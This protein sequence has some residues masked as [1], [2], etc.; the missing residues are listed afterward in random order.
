M[1]KYLM[2]GFAAIVFCGAI[3]S[4]SHDMDSGS[5]A[6]QTSVIEKYEKAF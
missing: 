4:C 2:K 1:K 3:A 5:D 6:V